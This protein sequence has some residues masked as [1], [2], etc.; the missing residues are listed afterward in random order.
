MA[1]KWGQAKVEILALKDEIFERLQDGH[2]LKKI[3]DDLHGVGRLTSG[4]AIFYRHITRLRSE[5]IR[6]RNAAHPQSANTT[7]RIRTS[8][9]QAP[10]STQPSNS[11]AATT[12]GPRIVD[13]AFN[14]M[15]VSRDPSRSPSST[16]DVDQDIWDGNLPKNPGAS[17]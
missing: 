13:A 15:P 5:A 2:T 16:A 10:R 4:R 1:A 9:P 11:P 3:Y 8:E 14:R 7:R 17:S 6:E 12:D